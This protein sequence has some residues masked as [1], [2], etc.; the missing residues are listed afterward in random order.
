[1]SES[2]LVA[3]DTNNAPLHCTLLGLERGQSAMEGLKFKQNLTNELLAGY[4]TS[5]EGR[6]RLGQRNST[7]F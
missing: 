3:K 1:M 5:H 6:N 4:P 7:P 2:S